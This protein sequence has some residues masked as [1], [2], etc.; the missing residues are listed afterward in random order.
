MQ[1]LVQSFP[2]LTHF[3]A[4]RSPSKK[5]GSLKNTQNSVNSKIEEEMEDT[6][7]ES[8]E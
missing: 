3:I 7:E 2:V 6:D 5:R 1:T 4:E 8:S